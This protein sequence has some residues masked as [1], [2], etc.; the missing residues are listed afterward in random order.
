LAS[1]VIEVAFK[2]NRREFFLWETDEIPPVSS[3]IIVEADRGEDLGHVHAIGDFALFRNRKIPHGTGESAPTKKARRIA[4]SDDVRKHNDL[5]SQD[6][7]ARRK[8]MERVRANALVMKVSDAEWQWDRRK[9]TFYFTAE[10]RVD[11]RSLVRDLA[12]VF[13][14]RIELCLL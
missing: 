3:P 13:R 5:R 12:A 2:G 10:K 11:F 4:S 9:L 8:A 1:H 6:E 7:D 14:T